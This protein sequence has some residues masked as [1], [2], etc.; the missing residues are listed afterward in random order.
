V[1][2]NSGATLED[3][4]EDTQKAMRHKCAGISAAKTFRTKK[5]TPKYAKTQRKKKTGF[6]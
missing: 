3:K 4:K 2:K 5:E 1:G 6:Y